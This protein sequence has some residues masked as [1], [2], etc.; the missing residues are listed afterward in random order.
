MLKDN[1]D[2]FFL[3]PKVIYNHYREFKSIKITK[4]ILII[5]PFKYSQWPDV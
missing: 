2:Y 5:T 4:L 3:A 1:C